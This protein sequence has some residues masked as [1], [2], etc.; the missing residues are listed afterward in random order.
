MSGAL[1][2]VLSALLVGFALGWAPS[3][4][5][6]WR[7]RRLVRQ[8]S[9][10]LGKILSA[11]LGPNAVRDAA[12]ALGRERAAEKYE[13]PEATPI[14]NVRDLVAKVEPPPPRPPTFVCGGCA[15][16]R[17]LSR[18]SGA[19][20]PVTGPC[21]I[22]STETAGQLAPLPLAHLDNAEPGRSPPEYF[23]LGGPEGAGFPF[24]IK[25]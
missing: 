12:T 15:D 11:T 23:P 24:K 5:R 8:C 2:E 10:A 20:G 16:A 7:F 6:A 9:K 1:F 13:A 25:P 18:I 17:H 4:Y 19:W 21:T 3:A 14:G 22:C